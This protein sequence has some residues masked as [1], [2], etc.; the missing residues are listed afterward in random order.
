M[1]TW[2]YD[3][4]RT[5]TQDVS[6]PGLPV[7]FRSGLVL[8]KNDPTPPLQHRGFAGIP[9]SSL[10]SLILLALPGR[11]SSPRRPN[12]VASGFTADRRGLIMDF[13]AILA[14]T[15]EPCA[16]LDTPLYLYL[17]YTYMRNKAEHARARARA[18]RS[19][20]LSLRSLCRFLPLRLPK[21]GRS[22]RLGSRS[23]LSGWRR[24]DTRN[25]NDVSIAHSSWPLS[26]GSG[27]SSASPLLSLPPP[28]PLLP[29][30]H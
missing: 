1:S 16:S 28:I 27:R 24:M 8:T 19:V 22:T 17:P 3:V 2:V 15:R 4:T 18:R 23:A 29:C 5:Q 30:V 10:P 14:F 21:R 13:Q 26:I 25:T 12:D 7:R 6:Q 11:E 9:P 20:R